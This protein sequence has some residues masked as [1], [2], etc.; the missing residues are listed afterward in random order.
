MSLT[1]DM[2]EQTGVMYVT[3]MSGP[4]RAYRTEVFTHNCPVRMRT[5]VL[6]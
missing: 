3:T 1:Q 5:A 6:K 2:E 4:I